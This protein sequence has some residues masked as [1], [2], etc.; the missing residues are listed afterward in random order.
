MILDESQMDATDPNPKPINTCPLCSVILSMEDCGLGDFV[1]SESLFHW[2]FL[3]QL[4][5]AH[6][7]S[8][9]QLVNQLA[10]L[11]AYYSVIV[12]KVE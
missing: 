12:V 6:N 9:G 10:N 3:H 5:N 11:Q 2:P 7:C 4:Q 1:C 8:W